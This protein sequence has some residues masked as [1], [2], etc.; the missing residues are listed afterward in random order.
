MRFNFDTKSIVYKMWLYFFLFALAILSVLW[1]LQIVFLQNYYQDMKTHEILNIADALKSKYGQT[2]FDTTL[3]QYSYKNNVMI[4]VTDLDG[5]VEF[6]ADSFGTGSDLSGP[7]GRI[8]PGNFTQFSQQI[9]EQIREQLL[10]SGKTEIYYSVHNARLKGLLL[11]YGALLNSQAGRKAILYIRSP[12]DPID[13][14]TAVLKSQL[15]YV[16]MIILLL[17]FFI[18]FLIARRFSRPIEML[19]RSARELGKGNYNVVFV[20]GSYS[21]IDQLA[22][23][24]NYATRELSKTERLRREL[25]ANVSHDLRTPLTMIRAYAEMLRDF[26][27]ENEEKRKLR[28]GVIVEEADRLSGLVNDMLNLSK[29][30][31]GSEEIVCQPFDISQMVRNILQRFQI[32]SERNGYK[33]V[34]S[35]EE[36][37]VVAAD[38]R[39]I[40]QVIY[41]LISN[42]VNYTGD[43]KRVEISLKALKDRIRCE[44]RDSGKGIPKE[45]LEVIWERYYK[46]TETHKRPVIGS[47]LGLSIVKSI[48]EAQ[49]AAYGVESAE[50]HG[51]TFWFE[52]KRE[53]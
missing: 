17:A 25:I 33:F 22:S 41:N 28:A 49:G 5:N 4:L 11:E 52:L 45:K 21:E 20:R 43:D 42:A 12:L 1:L 2:D 51:S 6:S 29:I 23:T 30:Q 27:S 50:G 53:K 44:V 40:E 48:L 39:R 13:S 24:L 18:A 19:T 3:Q 14:T 47:G 9:S 31:S 34:C 35:C 26:A 36:R 32:L 10:S 37:L 7:G 8:H 15:F 38:K 16:S 46:A